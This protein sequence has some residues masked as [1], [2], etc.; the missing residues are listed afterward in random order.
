[1]SIFSIFQSRPARMPL[2]EQLRVLADCGVKLSPEGTIEDLL[3]HHPR[4]EYEAQPFKELI[5]VL[6]FEVER[7]PFAPLCHR[8]WMCDYERIEDHGAYAEVIARLH[9]MSERSLLIS[10]ITDFVDV[11]AGT[12]WVEFDLAG[13]RIHWVAKVNNDSLDPSIIPKFD[14]LLKSRGSPFRFYSSHTD[15]GQSSFFACFSVSE[16][17]RFRNEVRFKMRRIQ[18]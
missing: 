16:F 7:E 15:F 13:E 1:M 8:L 10:A 14:A 11:E 4:E 5:P 6:G 17:E 3:S 12:A 2:E 9:E 18:E